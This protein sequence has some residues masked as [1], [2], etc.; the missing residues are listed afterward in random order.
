[1][2]QDYGVTFCPIVTKQGN[3]AV[4]VLAKTEQ[5]NTCPPFASSLKESK[6]RAS[7]L[8]ECASEAREQE[9]NKNESPQTVHMW[10]SYLHSLD[11]K[12]PPTASIVTFTANESDQFMFQDGRAKFRPIESDQ[13]H[14]T[15]STNKES[16]IPVFATTEHKCPPFASSFKE[17]E[18]AARKGSSKEV[19]QGDH[20]KDGSRDDA[21]HERWASYLDSL[22]EIMPPAESIA[23]LTAKTVNRRMIPAREFDWTLY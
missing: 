22:E 15:A 3:S 23:R 19:D 16:R 2:F 12:T 1:M 17:S 9:G 20:E 11:E 21:E 18:G 14:S 10:E 8:S 4:R 7:M 5:K 13:G 6:G